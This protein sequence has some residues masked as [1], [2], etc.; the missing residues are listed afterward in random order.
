[1]MTADICPR[2][3]H[4]YGDGPRCE[5][6]DL[7]RGDYARCPQCGTTAERGWVHSITCYWHAP[8]TEE[9]LIKLRFSILA[10]RKIRK[11]VRMYRRHE[12]VDEAVQAQRIQ[13]VIAARRAEWTREVERKRLNRKYWSSQSQG[14]DV[15][16]ETV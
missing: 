3:T 4:S 10:I 15:A 6:C 9:N 7:P 16:D 1:M 2:C 14:A 5:T 11:T 8:Y 12:E 13:E